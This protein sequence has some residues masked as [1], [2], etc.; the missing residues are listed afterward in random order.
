M[1]KVKKGPVQIGLFHED[2]IFT[3]CT[4]VDNLPLIMKPSGSFE[5]LAPG[6]IYQP[7]LLTPNQKDILVGP[8]TLDK[9]EADFVRH[10]IQYL[11]PNGDHPKSRK[12]PLAWEGRDVWLKR[13]IEKDPSS[14]RLRLDE[15]DWFYPDFILWIL[16][17]ENRIQTLGFVDPKGLAIGAAGG[18]SDYK[19]LSTIYMPHVVERQLARCEKPVVDRDGNEWQFR[20]RGVIVST[21]PFE[22][23]REHKKFLLNTEDLGGAD[24]QEEDYERARIV[25]QKDDPDTYIPK[26]LSLLTVDNSIDGIMKRAAEVRELGEAFSPWHEFDYDLALRNSEG[27]QTDSEYVGSILRNY[28]KLDDFGNFGGFARERCKHELFKQ[29]KAG[30]LGFGSEKA[31]RMAEHP[32]PCEELWKRKQKKAL[33]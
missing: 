12:T 6:S 32:T 9:H 1:S 14:F 3:T 18:W 25:F 29:A 26:V 15:S 28:L 16:D 19:I 27:Q 20:I 5:V 22:A 10:L 13:N 4:D 7:V 23:L 30:R 24:P 33:V 17:H 2:E 11:Y 21:S 8:G 31:S